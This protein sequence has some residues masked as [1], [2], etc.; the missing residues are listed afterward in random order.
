MATRLQ[1][2]KKLAI[3]VAML[4]ISLSVNA[5]TW[6]I[7]GEYTWSAPHPVGTFHEYHY[8]G[9]AVTIG[10]LE[11]NTI[12]VDSDVNGN[13]LDGAY[14]NDGNQVYYCK[15]NGT[16]YDDETLLYDYDLE[17]GDFFNDDNEHPMVVTEVTTITD[18][19]GVSRKK[20]SF[21]FIGLTDVTEFWI[22]GVGSNRG[23]MHVGQWEA[24]HDSDGEMYHLLC[25]HEDYNVIF[26]NPEYNDCD[27]PYA[28]EDNSINTNV[29]IYPNPASDIVKILNNNDLNISCVE[30]IDLTGRIVLSTEK[31]DN[32]DISVIPEG[33][34]FVKIIG[35]KTIV[36]KLFI[37]K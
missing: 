31:T 32:I 29:S 24:D 5:Q 10:G 33:Q 7:Y 21:S 8:Q 17:E 6:Y 23:F 3:F 22:E 36:K 18:L 11:Y 9:D 35:E 4:V 14:R 27:V 20:I 34:Y 15:W 13:Y 12:Y 16:S 19:N 1:N 26:V 37:S 30:I 2:L 28:V 25:Y